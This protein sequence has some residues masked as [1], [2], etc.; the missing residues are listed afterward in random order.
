MRHRDPHWQQRDP[1]D[2]VTW[3]HNTIDLDDTMG[4]GMRIRG[5]PRLL[6][7]VFRNW[8]MRTGD[9]D[10][11][12]ILGPYGDFDEQAQGNVWVYDNVYGLDQKPLVELSLRSAPQ[13]LHK[14][15]KPP[16]EP[17][18]Q[19]SG[20]LEL[21]LDI[22]PHPQTAR[23]N[24]TVATDESSRIGIGTDEQVGLTLRIRRGGHGGDQFAQGNPQVIRAKADPLVA[25]DPKS[26]DGRLEFDCCLRTDPPHLVAQIQWDDRPTFGPQRLGLLV[27]FSVLVPAAPFGTGVGLGWL[28][29]SVVAEPAYAG[30]GPPWM[31]LHLVDP[32]PVLAVA[33]WRG[34]GQRRCKKRRQEQKGKDACKCY[35]L[36]AVPFNRWTSYASRGYF[37]LLFRLMRTNL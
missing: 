3:H 17:K 33:R 10:V 34:A 9:L 14:R 36:H 1:G 22:N 28:Q 8:F 37:K 7:Q 5:T 4:V 6:G 35:S 11:L 13:I 25:H 31:R 32:L 18:E 12:Q 27:P 2:Y 26:I 16:L 30:K 20:N 21:D 23:L 19:V 24:H 15:P 29:R